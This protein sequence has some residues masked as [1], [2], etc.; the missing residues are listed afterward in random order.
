MRQPSWGR[1]TTKAGSDVTTLY[2]HVFN[3][4]TSGELAVPV[5]NA[6]KSCALL[7]NPSRKFQTTSG[8]NGLTVKLS[9]DA[10]DKIC[11]VVV[12]QIAGPPQVTAVGVVPPPKAKTAQ[13]NSSLAP[14]LVPGGSSSGNRRS[15]P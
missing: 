7:A 11:S 2:L 10:P 4:P 13:R 15:K 5:S 9:G 3:W 6:V 14:A 1:I 12:L 8:A